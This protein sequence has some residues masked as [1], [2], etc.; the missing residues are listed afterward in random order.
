M[1]FHPCL[2]CFCTFY[3]F[4]P[5][6]NE[7]L[8]KT[9]SPSILC[10]ITITLFEFIENGQNLFSRCRCVW[11]FYTYLLSSNSQGRIA[12]VCEGHVRKEEHICMATDRVWEELL[13]SYSPIRFQPQ[14]WSDRLRKSSTLLVVSLL[15]SLMGDQ[16]QRLQS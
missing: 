15:V 6:S 10:T 3:R 4:I 5:T 1:C 7:F 14:A 8:K 11:S 2:N 9:F 12:T 13:L 16:V